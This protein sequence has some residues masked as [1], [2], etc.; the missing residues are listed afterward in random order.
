LRNDRTTASG[1][2]AMTENSTRADLSRPNRSCSQPSTELPRTVYCNP[3]ATNPCP[4]CS[5]LSLA[6]KETKGRPRL[7]R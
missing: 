6:P 1:S 4:P 5:M 3:F 2:W 7:P